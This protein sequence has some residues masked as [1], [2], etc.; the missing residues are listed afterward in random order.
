MPEIYLCAA[1]LDASPLLSETNNE[2]VVIAEV[3]SALINQAIEKEAQLAIKSAR[4][5]VDD[6]DRADGDAVMDT[7]T[8]L[9]QTLKQ[10][11][12]F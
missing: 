2:A 12:G 3:E 1:A 5:Q 6:A 8:L 4:S 7:Q 9:K 10:L 11:S